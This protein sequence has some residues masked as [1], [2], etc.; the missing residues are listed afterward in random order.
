MKKIALS[1]MLIL[2][3]MIVPTI[4]YAADDVVE[5]S[6]EADLRTA[7]ESGKS[8]KLLENIELTTI[9]KSECAAKDSRPTAIAINGKGSITI[10]GNGHTVSTSKVRTLFEIYDA[11]NEFDVTFYNVKLDNHYAGGRCIDTRTENIILNIT[12]STLTTYKG[13]Y[14]QTLC[15]GG[16]NEK[17]IDINITNSKVISKSHYA[18]IAFNP[19]KLTINNCESI[20]GFAAIYMKE[21]TSGSEISVNNSKLVGT[22]KWNVESGVFGTI[23]LEDNGITIDVKNSIVT[24][25]Q[26]GTAYQFVIDDRAGNTVTV[27]NSRIEADT[28]SMHYVDDTKVTLKNKT[29]LLDP[30]IPNVD[31]VNSFIPADAVCKKTGDNEYT[32]F[33]PY[34]IEIGE[35]TG[36]TV[37]VDKEKA[38]VGETVKIT[39]KAD[40]GYELVK[41]TVI[42]VSDKEVK[43]ENGE[44]TMPDMGVIVNAEFKLIP[45]PTPEVTPTP[46]PT[47]DVTQ[48]VELPEEVEIT[49]EVEENL[50]ASLKEMAKDNKELADFIENNDVEIKVKL[51]EKEVEKTEKE[52][53][54]KAIEKE[55]K[56]IKIAKYLDI[57]VVVKNVKDDKQLTTIPELK[58]EITFSVAIPEDLPEVEKGYTR[59]YYIIRNHNGEI[60]IIKNAKLSEDGK[61]I[62]FGSSKFS[63]YAIAYNDV[64]TVEEDKAPEDTTDVTKPEDTKTEDTKKDN[65]TIGPVTGDDIL[66]YVV[67]LIISAMGIVVL[68][69]LN[70]SKK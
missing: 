26:E 2:V 19:I 38:I 21:N 56:G 18:I 30:S 3:L 8:V 14:D 54:E 33:E 53:I 55:V 49:K 10:D 13:A 37:S 40:K 34:T 43:V 28:V 24:A 32:V 62:I 61:S 70:I 16:A 6:T 17:T 36:G 11:G 69:K 23:T 27:S 63:T 58:N 12:D 7:L 31:I 51:N 1:I 67:S 57:T 68:R 64:K 66:V 9:T 45:T 46:I 59:S 47:P 25:K 29:I 52:N 50:I 65:A 60:E 15:I 44:F 20:E 42:E 4:I 39:A 35:V 5:V 22:N 48:D 41:I